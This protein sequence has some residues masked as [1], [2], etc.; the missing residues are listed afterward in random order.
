MFKNITKDEKEFDLSFNALKNCTFNLIKEEISYEI[1]YAL[2][3]ASSACIFKCYTNPKYFKNA[4]ELIHF[5]VENDLYFSLSHQ[6]QI[7][8]RFIL[9][10]KVA[11]GAV[12]LI[13]QH[14]LLKT[15]L[16]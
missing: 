16:I 3:Q 7:Q 14:N 10:I 6:P 5:L 11:L 8:Q 4:F 13:G 2:I 12:R 1:K 9:I 15:A